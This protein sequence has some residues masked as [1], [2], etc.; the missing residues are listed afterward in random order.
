[1]GEAGVDGDDDALGVCGIFAGPEVV[2]ATAPPL[3][4]RN[5]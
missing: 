1:M 2:N 5:S 3:P 4:L